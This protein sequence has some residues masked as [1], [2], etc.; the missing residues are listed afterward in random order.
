MKT[1][2]EDMAPR[3]VRSRIRRDG[4]QRRPYSAPSV[5]A[6]AKFDTIA[7]GCGFY[8][9]PACGNPENS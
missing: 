7:L 6:N 4:H 9:V 2:Y 3:V 5:S 1:G 8:E